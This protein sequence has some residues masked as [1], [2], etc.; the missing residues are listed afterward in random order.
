MLILE[1]GKEING[2][3]VIQ[4]PI[5][6]GGYAS[7]WRA[8]DKQLRRD[9]A[10]K[11]L[12]KGVASSQSEDMRRVLT[13]ARK[14]A[15]LVH[16]NIVQV[17]DVL[18]AEGEFLILMEYVDG[19]SLDTLLRDQAIKSELM[20]L[21]KAMSIL[22]DI[23]SGVSFA[24]DK[25]TIHRDLTPSNIL[26][27]SSGIPKVADFGIATVMKSADSETPVGSVHGGTGNRSYMSPEQ[28]AGEEL[29]P[30]SD[31]FTIGIIGYL[32]LTGRH[33]FAHPSGLFAISELIADESYVPD[34]PRPSSNL[35]VSDQRLHREYSAVIM[36]LL[37]RERAG[38]F[39][40]ASEAVLSLEAVTPFQECPKCGERLPEHFRFCGFC[41]S[42]TEPSVD[43]TGP[44]EI[45]ITQKQTVDDLIR[46]GFALSRAGKWS[47]AIVYYQDALKLAPDNQRALRNLGFALNSVGRFEEAENVL[48]SG[49]KAGRLSSFHEA[50]FLADRA[51]GRAQLK[52]YDQALEDINTALRLQP[53]SVKSLLL[54]ARIHQYRGEKQLA[55]DDAHGVLKRVPDHTGALRLI[56]QTRESEGTPVS[57]VISELYRSA[58]RLDVT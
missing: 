31:L 22:R 43:T 17:Y 47:N 25:K 8:T 7:V 1:T 36:R 2:R 5:G 6:T 51:Y 40:S 33:P 16:T 29:D 50:G 32:L 4:G 35:L 11:R 18:E 39:S 26:V 12:F 10:L 52:K 55:R 58:K 37:N 3:Y 45:Q 14:H 23:L 53:G 13:E 30:T 48:T 54:R 28:Q 27:T 15:Q 21:D 41:G 49:L 9:V 38:R 19:P 34:S 57:Q 42:P 46:V 44:L 24:H 20:P 56:E